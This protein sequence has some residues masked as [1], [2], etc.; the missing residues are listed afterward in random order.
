MQDVLKR[1]GL[2]RMDDFCLTSPLALHKSSGI[3]TR[4]VTSLY[5]GAEKLIRLVHQEMAVEIQEMRDMRDEC[6]AIR[7]YKLNTRG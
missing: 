1:A 6:A 3:P 2:E 7:E 5:V 4:A